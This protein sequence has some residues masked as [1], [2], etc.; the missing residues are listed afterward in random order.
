M[1]SIDSQAPL[2]I[3]PSQEADDSG[4]S[5]EI[6]SSTTAAM[7]LRQSP[8]KRAM[9]HK[10]TAATH[11]YHLPH[12]TVAITSDQRVVCGSEVLERIRR[13]NLSAVLRVIRNV[14]KLHI[15]GYVDGL[16]EPDVLALITARFGSDKKLQPLNEWITEHPDRF[17][18]LRW[19][20]GYTGNEMPDD[21]AR[22]VRE[23]YGAPV[24]DVV[25]QWFHDN[26]KRGN[27]TP[28][29]SIGTNYTLAL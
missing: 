29:P 14:D 11:Q 17:V 5:D 20:A 23:A 15:E 8:T 25:T 22:A 26:P 10:H 16:P 4:K 6:V 12:C 2:G 27:H 18:N 19:K 7:W 21:M 3:Q 28:N 24:G 1:Y 13:S 9:R